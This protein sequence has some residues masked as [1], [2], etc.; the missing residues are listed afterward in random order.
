MKKALYIIL[1]I[2]FI[3]GCGGEE[4]KVESSLPE[5]VKKIEVAEHMNSG[6]YTY[7]RGEENG[8]ELWIAVRAMPVEVGEVYYYSGSMTMNDF[9]SES[10]DRT[11]ETIHFVDKISKTAPSS[12]VGESGKKMP[13]MADARAGH[14]KPEVKAAEGI[15]VEPAAHG[16]NIAEINKDKSSLDG[17]IVKVRGVVT[18]FN[19]GIMKRNWIHIQD[20]TGTGATADLTVT[21]DQSAK[22]GDV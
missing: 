6:G 18:K 11:F 8:E 17:K 3:I 7:I 2:T 13:S 1:V 22:V 10:L 16:M 9:Q 5:G 21:S 19:G 20:G 14:G 12:D 4:Q 15:N